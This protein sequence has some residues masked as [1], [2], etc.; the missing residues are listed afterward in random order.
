MKLYEY[1]K[2]NSY[3]IDLFFIILLAI[4][5]FQ[6]NHI[7]SF[8]TTSFD[9]SSLNNLGIIANN[10]NSTG[11]HVVPGSLVVNGKTSIKNNMTVLNNIQIGQDGPVVNYDSTNG[12][13]KIP[14][15]TEFN[16]ALT[17]RKPDTPSIIVSGCV[18]TA[19][20]VNPDILKQ[21]YIPPNSS[22]FGH[23]ANAYHRQWFAYKDGNNNIHRIYNDSDWAW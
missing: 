13:L 8:G 7:E 11:T 1:Y 10:L 21:S 17:N 12:I 22:S 9:F 5:A 18:T 16:N 4:F 2:K 23:L 15:T 3:L 14:A 19:F 6:K 20:N